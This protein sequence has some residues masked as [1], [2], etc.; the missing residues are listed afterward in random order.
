MDS[1]VLLVIVVAAVLLGC[2]LQRTSGMGT[3]LVV[4][5]ALVLTIGPVA[6]VYLTNITTVVSAFLMTLAVRADVDWGRF[7]RIAPVVVVGAVPA[8]LLVR[9]AGPG[10]LEVIIGAVLLLALGGTALV[11]DVPDVRPTPAGLAAGVAGGFLNTAVGV[12]APA[13]LVYAHATRWAQRSFAATLQPVFLAMG[14]VSV[15]TKSTLGAAGPGGLPPW[16]LVMAVVSAVPVGVVIGGRVARGVS[17]TAA[18]RLAVVVVTLGA[19]GTLVRGV[20]N[21]LGAG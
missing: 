20:A 6:G 4:S 8:A 10:W 21:L 9:E 1:W 3:G 13:M 18:R 12:S 2:T 15:L 14:V 16:P 17:A 19:A 5:P 7:L 11:P